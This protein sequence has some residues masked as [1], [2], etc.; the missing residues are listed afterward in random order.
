MFCSRCCWLSHLYK[1]FGCGCAFPLLLPQQVC[2][3]EPCNLLGSG[4]LIDRYLKQRFRG[5]KKNFCEHQEKIGITGAE[6]KKGERKDGRK[7]GTK[8]RRKEDRKKVTN[9][10]ARKR[11][12]EE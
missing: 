10:Q 11:G 3:A 9:K 7:K 1:W 5:S 8:E 4:W 2:N 6:G 12:R